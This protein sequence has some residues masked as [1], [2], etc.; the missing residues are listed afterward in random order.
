M[1]NKILKTITFLIILLHFTDSFILRVIYRYCVYIKKILYND[2]LV[3]L[4]FQLCS[5]W[6]HIGSLKVGMIGVFA[7]GNRH[8]FSES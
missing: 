5:Q 7:Y 1:Q 3:H 8:I 6:C 4:S 2:L